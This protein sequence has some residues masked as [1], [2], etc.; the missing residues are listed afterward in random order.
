MIPHARSFSEPVLV[1]PGTENAEPT[2]RGL[3]EEHAEARQRQKTG[4]NNQVRQVIIK[5]KMSGIKTTQDVKA[6]DSGDEFDS[7]MP[8][9]ARKVLGSPNQPEKRVES[10]EKQES[11]SQPQVSF[12]ALK[13]RVSSRIAGLRTPNKVST[14]SSSSLVHG[15]NTGRTS[16]LAHHTLIFK[17][18]NNHKSSAGFKLPSNFDPETQP[19]PTHPGMSPVKSSDFKT[20]PSKSLISPTKYNQTTRNGKDKNKQPSPLKRTLS[21]LTPKSRQQSFDKALPPTPRKNTPPEFK[22]SAT[23]ND[24]A[25]HTATM[26]ALCYQNSIS[27]QSK[28]EKSCTDASRAG[29]RHELLTTD[30]RTSKLLRHASEAAVAATQNKTHNKAKEPM[31]QSSRTTVSVNGIYIKNAS[32]GVARVVD[33]PLLR[34]QPQQAQVFTADADLA[35]EIEEDF[36]TPPLPTSAFYSPRLRFGSGT[37]YGYLHTGVVTPANDNIPPHDTTG[38]LNGKYLPAV[39]YKP[40]L[41]EQD[42][43]QLAYTPSVY[44]ITN[45][46]DVFSVCVRFLLLLREALSSFFPFLA[47]TIV[48]HPYR[49]LPPLYFILASA[50]APAYTLSTLLPH[51]PVAST[52]HP[53]CH[54]FSYTKS[55]FFQ[56][57]LLHPHCPLS[58]SFRPSHDCTSTSA[59]PSLPLIYT[60]RYFLDVALASPT[61]SIITPAFLFNVLNLLHSQSLFTLKALDLTRARLLTPFS[62]G[63]RPQRQEVQHHYSCTSQHSRAQS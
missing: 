19:E 32:T 63:E 21:A 54:A 18:Q 56:I 52:L 20:T 41:P 46:A 47:C 27:S 51:H 45:G 58:S 26:P 53:P 8:P 39:A 23:I 44:T 49:L 37:G 15:T 5:H 13:Q 25:S 3:V 50:S 42:G 36:K 4:D 11:S 55:V 14:T 35:A 24:L 38:L 40:T 10:S 48:Q 17:P 9:K 12:D 16:P 6:M 34:N 7:P 28:T 1:P 61:L 43:S 31:K 2:V 33:E 60:H 57:L 62:T 22:P 30:E 59:P 29:N